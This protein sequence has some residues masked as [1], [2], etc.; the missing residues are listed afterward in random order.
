[1]NTSPM[2][3]SPTNMSAH[4]YVEIGSEEASPFP[5]IE[6][7]GSDNIDV[8]RGTSAE[9]SATNSAEASRPNS[10]N[11]LPPRQKERGRVRFN[12][13]SEVN[14]TTNKRSNFPLRDRSSEPPSPTIPKATRPALGHARKSSLQRH[15]P[16]TLTLNTLPSPSHSPVRGLP[17]PIFRPRPSVLR[18]NSYNSASG[19]LE[20]LTE[21]DETKEREEKASSAAAARRR[22]E[23]N[24]NNVK[25]HSA[26]ATRR[27]SL[28][29]DTDMD[30]M[31]SPGVN[32]LPPISFNDIPLMDMSQMSFEGAIS[33]SDDGD[34]NSEKGLFPQKQEV[35]STSEAHKLVRAHTRKAVKKVLKRGSGVPDG[36]VSGA[37]TPPEARDPND[38]VPRPEK[39]R[40]GILSS[41]MKLDKLY[42]PATGYSTPS[43]SRRGSSTETPMGGSPSQTMT[44]GSSGTTTP[45]RAAKKAKWYNH[46]NT[47]SNASQDTLAGLIQA[48]AML[49]APAAGSA[50]SGSFTSTTR[51]MLGRR[52]HSGRL[53][54][55]AVSRVTGRPRLEDEIR[56]TVHIAETIN[57]QRYL[58]KLC[59]TLM[60]YGAPTH[61]LEEYMKMSA[62][63]LE[64]DGQ[65]LYIP[66]CMIISFDDQRTHTTEVKLV[67][68]PQGVDLGK[69]KDVHQIYKEV[70]HDLIGVEEATQR[71]DELIK[72]PQKHHPWLL[73]LV[74]GFASASV[75]PFAF[76]ARLVD[77]PIAFIL[78]CLLGIL[79][80]IVAPRSDL[81]GNVFEISAAV[82]T[83]FLARAFGSIYVRGEPLFCFSA[84]AQ[85]SIALILPGYMI[86][87][88]C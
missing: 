27:N 82:L 57:R 17:S 2:N 75:G 39:Y 71:L 30:D 19:D 23:R 35:S 26:P 68:V 11:G 55:H 42:Q 31:M 6:I 5:A 60:S 86:R 72:K 83:S 13:S 24:A 58:L 67:K 69:L 49:G 54:E 78:G 77:L 64:I 63:V 14:D 10:S 47:S 7:S 37:N 85:S 81:Y 50:R 33:D 25:S 48:S 21:E 76:N 80:L 88:S 44:P 52:S 16:D 9:I 45:M 66:G 28:E 87:E 41:L 51:P 1:M 65:F 18:N 53:L 43:R 20:N 84:L 56:I 15:V 29:E 34:D 70:V 46:R 38:Y 74:Y 12:S 73:V 36:L 61:R 79:Q 40:G 8:S 3:T 32:G 59:R 4:P 62:R 22:A